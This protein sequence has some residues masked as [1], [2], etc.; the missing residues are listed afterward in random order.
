MTPIKLRKIEADGKQDIA[1]VLVKGTIG[2]RSGVKSTLKMLRLHTKNV[3]VI[4]KNTPSFM[5]MINRVK[6][7]VTYGEVSDETIKLLHDKRGKKDIA[8]GELKPY[9][10]LN[11]PRKGFERKGTKLPFT[12]G[13]AL[14][15][16][17]DNINDLIKRMI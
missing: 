14:G 2:A 3:C 1:V 5:G 4:V 9:F 7:F 17:G 16:R 10:R 15:Y 11:P 13:G 6:D 8:T 12:I